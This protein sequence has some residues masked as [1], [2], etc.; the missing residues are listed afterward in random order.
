MSSS[1]TLNSLDETLTLATDI[2]NQIIRGELPS[3]VLL[4]GDLG[5]GKTTFTQGIAQALGLSGPIPSPT[6]T[7]MR[8][9]EIPKTD[10]HTFTQLIHTDLYRLKAP[11]E[12]EELELSKYISDPKTILIV[13]WPEKAP[14]LWESIP[15]THLTFLVPSPDQRIIQI[16]SH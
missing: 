3:V 2:T 7:I 11:W 10:Q 1:H 9:Y 6:Y 14:Q 4:S 8:P 15:H 5:G 16:I 12:A 13:E